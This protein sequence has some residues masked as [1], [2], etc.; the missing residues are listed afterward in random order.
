MSSM[1]VIYQHREN[2]GLMPRVS[3]QH[4]GVSALVPRVPSSSR[5]TTGRGRVA[6]E[7]PDD[8]H[9]ED[10]LDVVP[11]ARQ[12]VHHAD[13]DHWIQDEAGHLAMVNIRSHNVRMNELTT[14]DVRPQPRKL[15]PVRRI[16]GD[17]RAGANIC[18]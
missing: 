3:C 14:N 10:R 17:E 2:R 16:L 4:D 12:D 1:T 18:A 13:E 6:C 8:V 9:H 11:Q 5:L 15:T 7:D